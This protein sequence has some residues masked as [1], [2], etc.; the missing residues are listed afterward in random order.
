MRKPASLG[1]GMWKGRSNWPVP[2]INV[3]SNS[4]KILGIIHTNKYEESQLINSGQVKS[5]IVKCT[6]LL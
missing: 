1:W 2:N 4:H 3:C 6:S 5:D